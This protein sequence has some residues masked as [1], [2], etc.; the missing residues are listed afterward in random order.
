MVM[1]TR[2]RVAV[3]GATGRLGRHVI[4]VLAA[5]GH[6]V[7]PISR[8][9]GVDL[10]TGAGLPAA[11][12]GVDCIVDAASGPSPAQA[13]ATEFFTTA[14]QNLQRD[15]KQAG[16]QRIIVVS[17]LGI[18]QFTAGYSAAKLAHERAMLSGSIPVQILRAAQ[19]HELVPQLVEW[20]RHDGVSYVSPMRIQPV[21]AATVAQ[22]IADLVS[23][24]IAVPKDSESS[25]VEVAGPREENALDIARLYAAR[26]GDPV[27]IEG[28]RDLNDPD[29]DLFMNGTLL[30]GEQAILAGPT[31]NEWLDRMS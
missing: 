17:I 18:D 12:A 13:P 29:L 5:Q 11:L 28:A 22:V 23:G 10:L 16:V 6:D 2:D 25:M 27:T 30:P 1:R 4:D 21:A 31:F 19:F 24:S 14:T 26:H 9:S 8:S 3:A 15:G 20:G 7:V